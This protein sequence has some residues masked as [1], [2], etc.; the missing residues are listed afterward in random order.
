MVFRPYSLA[1][2]TFPVDR[3]LIVDC[4]HHLP[5]YRG[6]S[7]TLVGAGGRCAVGDEEACRDL[8]DT[9]Q[10]MVYAL[11]Y[12]LLASH[13]E[14]LDLSQEVFLRVF[15]TIGRFQARASL[16][17]WIYR[18]VVNGARNRR[19]WFQRHRR[20]FDR[21]QECSSE[22]FGPLVGF[23]VADGFSGIGAPI[24]SSSTPTCRSTVTFRLQRV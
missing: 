11:G 20:A 19:R 8:V 13:E 5:A 9:H 12:Q 22:S 2:E 18:I 1:L 24:S 23:T 3:S 7:V 21:S 4:E 17:T 14:A 16:R 15:R 6:H 10:R